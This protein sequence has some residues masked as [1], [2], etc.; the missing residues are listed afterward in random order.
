MAGSSGPD[1]ITT[2]GVDDTILRINEF[3]GKDKNINS[4]D[5]WQDEYNYAFYTSGSA[6]ISSSFTLNSSW[7]ASNNKPQAVEFRF[8]NGNWYILSSDG[9]KQS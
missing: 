3:G 2:F 8:C 7:N 4:Y 9:L 6:F 5:N 1:L